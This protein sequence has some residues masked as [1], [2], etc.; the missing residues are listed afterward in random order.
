[1]LLGPL[2]VQGLMLNTVAVGVATVT[3]EARVE[4]AEVLS[5][6]EVLAEVGP[7]TPGPLVVAEAS[8]ELIPQVAEA[9]LE[10]AVAQ[11]VMVKTMPSDAGTA[12]GAV[13]VR[14]VAAR[15][16]QAEPVAHLG[17]AVEAEEPLQV[18]LVA[19]GVQ[20]DVAKL[21]FGRIR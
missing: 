8:G 12:A 4:T 13:L 7:M 2:A 16:A 20:A 9:R 5:M 17:V 6:A 3:L 19:Q 14:L 21:G 10:P 15:A 11:V 1:M 18:A